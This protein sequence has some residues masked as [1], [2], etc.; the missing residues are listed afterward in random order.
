MNHP[1][2]TISADV[3]HHLHDEDITAA[4]ALVHG[5]NNGI[6]LIELLELL[7]TTGNPLAQTLIP[8]VLERLQQLRPST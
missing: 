1:V 4:A 2:T 6:A 5:S 7:W 3:L 8:A